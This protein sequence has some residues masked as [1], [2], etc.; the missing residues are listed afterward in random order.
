MSERQIKKR[1]F[2]A[3]SFFLGL[4][5]GAAAGTAAGLLLAPAS[6]EQTRAKLQSQMK[7]GQSQATD[8]VD[9][10]KEWSEDRQSGL[11]AKFQLLKQAFQ[12]GKKAAVQ[13]HEQLTTIEN[14]GD[15]ET[16]NG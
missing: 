12:A 9:S 7:R 1:R 14:I 13:K 3:G 6:G 8:T 5:F 16:H 10:I 2:S 15:Q 4:L 11:G